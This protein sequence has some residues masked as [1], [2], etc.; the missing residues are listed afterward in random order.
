MSSLTIT[1]IFLITIILISLFCRD[2]RPAYLGIGVTIL[3]ALYQGVINII[4][5]GALSIFTAITYAYFNLQLNK[6]LKTSLFIL[7][8]LCFIL[9]AFHKVPGFFNI[10]AINKIQ[11]SELSIPFSMYLNF[12]K[13][14]P[15]LIIFSVSDLY[16][17]EKQEHTNAIRYTS[18][19]L[20][21]CIVIIMVLSLI[22]GYVL[23]EPKI[24][25]ILPIWAINNFFFVCIAEETFFRGFLQRTLQ[26]L[27]P[28]RQILAVIIASLIFGVAHFQGGLIYIALS[29]IC[30]FFY[31]YTYYKT[32]KILCSMIVHFGLNLCHLLLFT[33]PALKTL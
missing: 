12:D 16:I 23:F 29:T 28:N 10:L 5:V 26:N 30:G 18:L 32:S 3:A 9:F 15:A 21:L 27:L 8:S 1:Y 14:M 7:I 24:P 11:L 25:S 22:S 13:I 20:L 33:Y 6:V 4:G 17:L 31:G 19:S 2:K